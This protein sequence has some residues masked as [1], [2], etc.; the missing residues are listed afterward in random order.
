MA[1]FFHIPK[2]KGFNIKPRYWDPEKE[3]RENRERR[4]NAELGIKE[5]GGGYRPYI[6]KGAFR[7]GMSKGRWNSNKQ[8]RKSNIRLLII[9]LLLLLLL[10]LFMK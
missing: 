10:Y 3:N 6:G 9:F 7:E 4:I 1:N 8:R 5:E 2:P